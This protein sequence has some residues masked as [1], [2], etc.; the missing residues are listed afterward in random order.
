MA[1][2]SNAAGVVGEGSRFVA[3]DWGTTN[4]RAFLIE[5]GKV[6]RTER[7]DH[8]ITAVA[9]GAF[10]AETAAL[11]ERFDGLPM[12]LAGMVGSNRGWIDAGYLPCP[13]T[14]GDLA[15][16]LAPAAEGVWIVPGVRT[17]A[18]VMRGEEVQLLG[19]VAAG[20]APPDAL[21]AQPGTHNKWARMAGGAIAGFATAMTGELF[22]LLKRHALIGQAM[23]GP[24]TDGPA[25]RD[26]VRRSAKGDWL[27]A[28]FQVRPASILGLRPDADAAA[29]VSGLLLGADVRAQVGPGGT[30]YMLA[31]AGLGGLYAAALDEVGARAVAVDSHA[32]FVAGITRIWELQ[33]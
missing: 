19:A 4:R 28:L 25:F 20:L 9:P 26:G 3:V 8:G 32:A 12:L 29:Y 21:L 14:L 5:D 7:D 24:V 16:R 1:L 10:A 18:D 23:T 15:A 30:V 31:D 6:L 27:T 17:D 11:R 22:A 2:K 33:P 13:A